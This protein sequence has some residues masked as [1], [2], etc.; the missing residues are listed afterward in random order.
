VSSQTNLLAPEL[1]PA[2]ATRS[3]AGEITIAGVPVGK[4][5]AQYGTPLFVLDEAD[6]RARAKAYH[7][8]FNSGEVV[9]EVFYA[10]K[11]FM[12]VK[13]I[14][15]IVDE[16]LNV[17]V[18]TAGELEVA[19]RAGV[20]PE[21][22]LFHGNNKS[23]AELERAVDVGVGRIVLDSFIE[24]E[25]LANIASA[26][27]VTVQVLIRLTVGVEAHTHDYISTAHEDQK[28][29][30]S[31]ATGAAL[32]AAR[33]VIE[34]DSLSLLG[35]HSHIGSQI[36]DAQGF[37]ISARRV[38]ETAVGI[39]DTLDFT[40]SELNL[41]GGMGIA[42]LGEDDPLQVEQM[43]K[44]LLEILIEECQ[45]V[46]FPVP[47]LLVEPGRAIIGPAGITVYEVGTTK[48]VDVSDD[49]A[50]RYVSVD[51][52]MSDNIRPALYGAEYTVA[53]A[54]RNSDAELIDSRV[55]GKHC[56]SG[57]ILIRDVR[58]FA[59]IGPGDLLA[60]AATGAYCRAMASN[61]NHMVRPAVVAVSNG[62]SEVVLRRETVEDLL[63]LDAGV[64]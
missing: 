64:N 1:W 62:A 36:F 57:D 42:Y 22:I 19:L 60:V 25:R 44:A 31:I 45:R 34:S 24:I 52:G 63:A 50:R 33:M 13:V 23:I 30:L 3:G 43:A 32:E 56:E 5:A 11:A 40:V 18:C 61:Y 47:R 54:S 12:A 7:T 39:R 46:H 8:A 20:A 6:V 26:R 21:R 59:D 9:T 58:M 27:G 38:I 55:V 35:L 15:W 10:G 17:D 28:F 48:D 53:L 37:E 51:G 49:Q 4:L 41:G 2:S 16:G 14:K 29:G